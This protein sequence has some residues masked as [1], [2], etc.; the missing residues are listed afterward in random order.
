MLLLSI[1]YLPNILFSIED[2]LRES[3]QQKEDQNIIK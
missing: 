1:S 2:T 3:L